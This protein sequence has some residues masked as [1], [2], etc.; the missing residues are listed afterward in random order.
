MFTTN[1]RGLPRQHH[2]HHASQISF[3]LCLIFS[4]TPGSVPTAI[5]T[6]AKKAKITWT[7]NEYVLHKYRGITR[8]A[9]FFCQLR[10]TEVFADECNFAWIFRRHFLDQQT[11]WIGEVSSVW[12]SHQGE[13]DS[14]FVAN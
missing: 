11:C 9:K 12:P 2:V 8:D 7:R 13:G 3:E 10:I 1:L 4:V 14:V 5:L 6:F